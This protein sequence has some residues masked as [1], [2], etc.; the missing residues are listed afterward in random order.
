LPNSNTVNALLNKP[1]VNLKNTVIIPRQ[2]KQVGLGLSKTQSNF[3]LREKRL[4]PRAVMTPTMRD[5][6]MAKTSPNLYKPTQ[7]LQ[8]YN[9]A[10][11]AN[12]Y[13]SY[14]SSASIGSQENAHTMPQRPMSGENRASKKCK[15]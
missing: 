14:V 6:P 8:D 9:N 12:L 10:K 13:G 1:D 2:P 15:E 5:S 11:A 4:I 3:V 7:T